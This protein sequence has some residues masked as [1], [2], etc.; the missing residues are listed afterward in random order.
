[1]TGFK[2]LQ[3]VGVLV[4]LSFVTTD[5]SRNDMNKI[6]IGEYI[7]VSCGLFTFLMELLAFGIK[8]HNKGIRWLQSIL[9]I[10]AAA[11]GISLLAFDLPNS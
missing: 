7:F 9:Y 1:M 5:M 3:F 10:Y 4:L 8:S 11:Y 6:I 2:F